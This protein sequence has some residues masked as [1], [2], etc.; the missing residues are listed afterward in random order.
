MTEIFGPKAFASITFHIGGETRTMVAPI[1]G[2]QPRFPARELSLRFKGFDLSHAANA[3]PLATI[4]KREALQNHN[5][6][7]S[8]AATLANAAQS[9]LLSSNIAKPWLRHGKYC[10]A[11]KKPLTGKSWRGELCRNRW[12]CLRGNAAEIKPFEPE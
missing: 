6:S 4:S 12:G 10:Q 5:E 7:L 3:A 8:N 1:S 9:R 2:D 11:G